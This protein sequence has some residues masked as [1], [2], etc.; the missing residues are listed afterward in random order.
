VSARR[1]LY[2]Y[3]RVV[4]SQWR[5][6]ADAVVAWQRQRC[7]SQPGLVARLLRRPEPRDD[8]VT[9]MEAYAH[10][11]GI[12][13]ALDADLVRGAPALQRWL[14]GERHLERFDPLD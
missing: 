10:S 5:E 13:E 9:L 14:C 7:R 6:A 4:E 3:Y 1:E 2:V 12:D 11:R 8:Q